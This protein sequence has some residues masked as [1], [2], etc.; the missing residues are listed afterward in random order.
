MIMS[1]EPSGLAIPYRSDGLVGGLIHLPPKQDN[2]L[3]EPGSSLS[4]FTSLRAL[5]YWTRICSPSRAHSGWMMA[6]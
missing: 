6:H 3:I 5:P 1:G 2:M 4:K